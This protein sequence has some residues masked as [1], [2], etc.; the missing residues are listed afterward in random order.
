MSEM[1][2]TAHHLVIVGRGSLLAD[3]PTERF[4]AH[5]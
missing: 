2:L 1:A 4:I 5:P 3:T